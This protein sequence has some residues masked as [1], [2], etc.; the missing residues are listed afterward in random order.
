M[1]APL[2]ETMR[3]AYVERLGPVEEIVV[4]EL[5]VPVPGPT[6]VLV[7]AELV[8]ANPVDTLVRSGRYPTSVPFPFVVGRDV[9][10]TVVAAGPGT[11]FDVG[12]RVWSN[13]LGHDGRQGSFSEYA[14]VPAERCYRLPGGVDAGLAAA[15]AHPAAT[16]YLAWFVH[17]GLRPGRWVYVGGGGGNVGSAA[18]A[19]ARRAG[20]RVLASAQPRD[21]D[22]CRKAG[23]NV[24]FDYRDPDL[25][26][27]LRSAAPGGVDVFWETSG[28]HDVD[29]TADSV[30]TGGRVLLSAATDERPAFPVR[31]LY[32]RNVSLHGFVISRATVSQLADAARLIND[33]LVAGQLSARIAEV[34]PLQATGQ[35]HARLEAG[36]V[37]G[38][39]LVRP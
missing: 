5:G 31:D 33:M 8:A 24:I 30:V 11:P 21:H 9:V 16:A 32:T 7:A 22:R 38:R 12:E 36:A 14:V 2:A 20:A 6:D 26:G 3:A 23:A 39:L 17:G 1:A 28:H 15:V 10:G 29:L 27:H 34:L 19:M 25:A 35:V 4:G 37:T 18:I 13:S